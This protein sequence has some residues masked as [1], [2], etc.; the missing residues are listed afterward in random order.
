MQHM[1][2]SDEAHF[3]AQASGAWATIISGM[4]RSSPVRRFESAKS[5]FCATT[6]FL[7]FLPCEALDF[8]KPAFQSYRSFFHAVISGQVVAEEPHAFCLWVFDFEMCRVIQKTDTGP[9]TGLRNRM[10]FLEWHNSCLPI[11]SNT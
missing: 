1:S 2:S 6:F 10:L 9:H 3:M 5:V 4:H 7:Q 11:L 8:Q